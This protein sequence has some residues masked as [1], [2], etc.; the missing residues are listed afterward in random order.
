[1]KAIE[2][3]F[4][5]VFC[6]GNCGGSWL[7]DAISAHPGARAW[8]ELLAEMGLKQAQEIVGPKRR[9]E[10]GRIATDYFI[11]QATS[12][13]WRSVG[14]VKELLREMQDYIKP[15]D[16]RVMS[17]VRNPIKVVGYKMDS[18]TTWLEHRM[19]RPFRDE[20][21]MFVAHVEI[22]ANHFRKLI[23]RMRD[24]SEP[25]VRLEDLSASLV[26]PEAAYFKKIMRWLTRLEWTDNDVALVREHAKP[27]KREHI[28]DP[29]CWKPDEY[30][31]KNYQSPFAP[32]DRHFDRWPSRGYWTWESWNSWQKE[33]FL[34]EFEEIMVALGYRWD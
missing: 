13:R 23:A 19:D 7:A 9:D 22:Y 16:P 33:A 25:L 15:R 4:F 20:R 11:E 3:N 14:V 29:D 32:D 21:E 5:M 28:P 2:P 6:T 18:K 10:I 24:F 17:L 12:G 30:V 34:E 1:M 31:Y 27:R 26:T 8:E